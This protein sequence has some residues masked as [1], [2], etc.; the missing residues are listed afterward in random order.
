MKDSIIFYLISTAIY[1]MLTYV[2]MPCIIG[3]SGQES[4]VQDVVYSLK[5]GYELQIS[6]SP[7]SMRVFTLKHDGREYVVEKDPYD[8]YD[9]EKFAIRYSEIDFDDYFV[10]DRWEC[11]YSVYLYLYEKSTG[12]NLFKDKQYLESGYDASAN[13]LLYLDTDDKTNPNGN[14]TLLN[15]NN[16]TTVE[17]DVRRFIPTKD[18][19]PNYYWS[20]FSVSKISDQ[21][22]RVT[23]DGEGQKSIVSVISL[24]TSCPCH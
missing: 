16:L 15:L 10:L 22:V 1:P 23:Y 6:L 2:I 19:L 20:D 3:L 24:V 18:V 13:L 21:S 8:G 11:Q 14:L 5:N 9:K 7:D 17:I 4:R 12:K